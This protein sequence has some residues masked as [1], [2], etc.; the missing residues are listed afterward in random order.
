MNVL[1]GYDIEDFSVGM[2]ATFSK[3]ITEAD[4]VLFAGVSGDNNALHI[5]EEYARDHAI[6]GTHR[7]R[8]ADGQRDFRGGGQQAARAWRDLHEPKPDIPRPGQA[9][10]YRACH[11]DGQ[12]NNP[13]DETG[14]CCR[15][16][17]P[18]RA[19]AVIEGEALVKVGSRQPAP[20]VPNFETKHGLCAEW[21]LTPHPIFKKAKA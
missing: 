4:I 20:I 18:S 15:P 1:G 10:R 5:N 19:M 8:H 7:A 9:G 14:S 3:T 12:G 11:G 21:R 6:C 2:S 17:A 13:G 16:P